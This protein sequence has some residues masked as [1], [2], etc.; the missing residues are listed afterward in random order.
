MTEVAKLEKHGSI[1][2]LT[3]DSPPVNAL[4]LDVRRALLKYISMAE[5]DPEIEAVIL[6][7]AGQTFFAGAD[8]SEFG[9]PFQ[10][11]DLSV[12]CR[13]I[14]NSSK[15]IVAAIHG[16]AL[17]GGLE[18]ALCCHYRIAVPSARLGL[19]EVALGLL[20]GAGGTQR[21][22]RLIG[23]RKALEFI[24][25][26]APV[27]ASAARE[28]GIVDEVADEGALVGSALEY[29][30]KLMAGGAP[31]RRVRDL[32]DR[33]AA[34]RQQPEL[35]DEFRRSNARAFRGKDAP[36]SIVKA[37]EA[38]V[39]L[40]FEEGLAR[41]FELFV[42][43]E[44]GL[45][46]KAQIHA[47]F[48]ER[49]AS[50]VKD[51]P[52]DTPV[53]PV[54]TVGVVGAGTMGGGIAMNFLN[55]GIPVHIVEA[56]Q[57]NLDRGIATIRRNYEISLKRG[58]LTPEALERRMSLLHATLDLG[59]LRDC[60]LIIEAVFE[61]MPLKQE[62]F[63]KLDAVARDG[64]ILA[65]N[66]SFLDLNQIAR[67]TSR[68][69]HVIGLHFFS[70]AN[71][72]PLLEVVRGDATAKPVVATAMKLARK[73]GKVPVLSGVC[74]GFIANRAM[75]AR[76][77]QADLLLL[78]NLSPDAIDSAIYDYGFAMGP[79]RMLDLVGLD[80]IGRDSTERSV[81]KDLVAAGRMGQ[82]SGGGYYDYDEAR[83]ARPSEAALDIIR[84]HAAWKGIAQ[85][86]FSREEIVARLLHP[87]VNE[88]AKILEEGIAMRASD[89]DVAMI[90]GYN[91]PVQ[92]GGP[93]FW[94]DAV[95]LPRI[96]ET[97]KALEAE[98]GEAMRPS[99]LLVE[100]AESG[101]TFGSL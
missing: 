60:D 33:I 39:A 77:E 67:A 30:R 14:E 94:A 5:A 34:D 87:V 97:M 15:I 13:H 91:W 17:G 86:S 66:T 82:K 70:P 59:D 41:E 78:Q 43:L 90:K 6:A 31:L 54:R 72:M 53:L 49:T 46:A 62:I 7:C 44:K 63:A 11:P 55:V 45:Q 51:V 65:S 100:L 32:E 75:R 10:A 42:E 35:F 98:Q 79:F 26:G 58:K 27:S 29:V 74:D 56:A 85:R 88:G 101:R 64:A 22:P 20:P 12:V 80:V 57:A 81:A 95:G 96:V 52:G 16:T 21:I 23:A 2:V 76:T 61:S 73:I 50:K 69:D 40:P 92:T 24:T 4:G 28:M 37:I 99:R 84:A 89:I 83:A 36:E 1:A 38:A 68:P 25:G 18:V 71:V 8:I 19:P 47:F 48:A 9:K 3:I 93:M